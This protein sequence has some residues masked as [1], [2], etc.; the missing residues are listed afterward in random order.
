[1]D[2]NR[3]LLLAGI[4]ISIVLLGLINL[5]SAPPFWWDEGWTVTAARNWVEKGFYGPFLNGKPAPRGMEGSFTYTLPIAAT[6]R[7][8]GAGL[9]QA[10]LVVLM[11]ALLTI[12]LLYYLTRCFYGGAVAVMALI[13]IMC[14]PADHSIHAIFTGRQVL[15]EMPALF[16][17][18][19]GYALLL[20][21]S[22]RQNYWRVIL[23]AFSWSLAL[24]TK[25]Q[26]LSFWVASVLPPL[27]LLALNG[28]RRLFGL[29]IA[30]C[31]LAFFGSFLFRWLW[32]F[33][34][35]SQ[36]IPRQS[37]TGMYYAVA[38]V[39]SLPARLFSLIVLVL[40]GLP[41]LAG[42]TYGGWSVLKDKAELRTIQDIVKFSLLIFATSWFC[43]Y[44]FLSVGWIRY[45]FPAAFIG[46]I[47]LAKLFDKLTNNFDVAYTM[48]QAK[49]VFTKLRIDRQS[50]GALFVVAMLVLSVPRSVKMFYDILFLEADTSV[51]EAADFI[52]TNTAVN[53]LI[54]TYDSELFF[55]LSRPIHYPHDQIHV[56]L[57]RRTFLYEPAT[58]IDYDPLAADPDYLVVGPQ[59]KQWRLYDNIV[60]AKNFRLL[61]RYSRYQI[62]E[63]IRRL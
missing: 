12:G 62:Y 24:N 9:V 22:S 51:R 1:M 11:F 37:A 29:F 25:G 42:L 6:F 53:S 61:R 39:Y 28:R 57:I 23:A 30:T 19:A 10:R 36:T 43:W 14:L 59:S 44:L 3:Q 52:N 54:E 63:R 49:S 38:L 46:T 26:I 5:E 45:L 15:G 16:Y 41:T 60:E 18:L 4:W 31:A 58:R 56:E 7:L 17:L 35:V 55:F 47:F 32:E 2:S 34:I 20:S 40:F 50:L 48:D 21:Y 8:F 13:L 33:C 27:C